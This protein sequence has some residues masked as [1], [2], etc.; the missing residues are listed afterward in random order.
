MATMLLIGMVANAQQVTEQPGNWR[1]RNNDGN[2]SAAGATW[3]APLNTRIILGPGNTNV[4][5]LRWQMSSGGN[6][7]TQ[8]IFLEYMDAGDITAGPNGNW[9][10]VNG[11][12]Q[13]TTGN[14]GDGWDVKTP[15]SG[16]STGYTGGNSTGIGNHAAGLW[17]VIAPRGSA[18][19]NSSVT[20]TG[21]G[22][23]YA[24]PGS[25]S[26]FIMAGGAVCCSLT[27]VYNTGSSTAWNIGSYNAAATS[28]DQLLPPPTN[29]YSSPTPTN[30]RRAQF[31]GQNSGTQGTNY[32]SSGS[33]GDFLT[34][35]NGGNVYVEELEFA[36][37]AN[38]ANAPVLNHIY[39][40]RITAFGKFYNNG[41][42]AG[43]VPPGYAY[44]SPDAAYYKAPFPYLT[45]V[46][47]SGLTVSASS[48]KSQVCPSSPGITLTS[49]PSG[50]T[51]PYTYLWSGSGVSPT[52]TQ[53][54]SATPTVSGTYT[55]TITDN[56][57][58]TAQGTTG[59]VTVNSDPTV[60]ATAAPSA[61]CIG[62]TI[63]LT[64]SSTGTPAQLSGTV[65]ASSINGAPYGY[66]AALAFDGN[67]SS[68]SFYDD[69]AN[70]APWV[71]LDFG[72][73]TTIS[74]FIYYPR[75]GFEGRMVGG[76]FQGSNDA[77]FST[78][79]VTLAT[80]STQP[81]DAYTTATSANTTT[82]FRYVRYLGPSGSDGNIA[83][84]QV[85]NTGN[86][87]YTY[88]WTASPS[89]TSGLGSVTINPS[90]AT[91]TTAGTYTFTFKATDANGC[92]ATAT[93][94]TVTVNS[95]PTVTATGPA[96]VVCGGSNISLTATPSGGTS[97][98]TYLWSGSGTINTTTSQ[99][100]TATPASS[101]N[102]TYSV[103]VT[104]NKGCTATGTT[105]NVTYD[106]TAPSV[107]PQC[108]GTSLRLFEL[109]GSSWLWTT[110]SG[111]RFYP[112]NTYSVNNDS[113]TSHL[114]APY[115]R[116]AGNYTVAIVDAKGCSSS[117]TIPVTASSCSVLASNMTGL[118][119][120]RTGNTVALQWQAA[121]VA[122]IREFIVERSADGN[123]F[124]IAGKV[125][126]TTNS[127]Y[128][129]D[130][131]VSLLGCIKLYYRVQ[132]TGTDNSS[133][134]SNTVP[135]A[136][137]GND[138]SQYVLNIYP[139][140]V[141]SGSKL[142]INYSLPV[143]INKAQLIVTNILSGQQYGYILSN[144]GNGVNNTTIPVSSM[145]AGTYFVRI[146]SDKWVSKTIKVI[147]Q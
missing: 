87:G 93:T 22:T 96:S 100:P 68:S 42:N 53:N 109:N 92:S 44:G 8:Q 142:T 116:V 61:V 130:D 89:A 76:M 113:S 49:T 17:R 102:Y 75:I 97:P 64:G 84:M 104:D 57:G 3:M 124:I 111:G 16:V 128:H 86:S 132:E 77:A 74:K 51:T 29:G 85:F 98:Y 143:G 15:T 94:N 19:Y 82:A 136:C 59:T 106:N 81:A 101:G 6:Y 147:K 90:S 131:D 66:P 20:G 80:I 1:W 69:G 7:S 95:K 60:T 135:V 78:G 125:T 138:A 26:P 14:S 91:P 10:Y 67:T 72:A 123:N 35:S 105:A 126:A 103:T 50:G 43:G 145:A 115:I 55:V 119:T 122:D 88:L 140:P 48:N 24:D 34:N 146:I 40:F 79:V 112:D 71:G 39:F 117:A 121:N 58:C 99:N 120:Q 118:S 52:N 31:F 18:Q 62:G 28:D 32:P 5:R 2:A 25:G 23:A 144:A 70:S 4:V 114:Q 21:F 133:Y 33:A 83:E 63:T 141:V 27:D 46:Q 38:P 47:C 12:P 13:P 11:V 129:F 108:S 139:N 127:N 30:V 54:T 107:S 134:T 37:K 65:I 45:I 110:T 36:I 56:Q 41:V 73:A 9:Q 137:N